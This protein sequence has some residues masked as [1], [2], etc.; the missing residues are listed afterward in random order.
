MSDDKMQLALQVIASWKDTD[1]KKL[2]L[3]KSQEIIRNMIA[4]A[5]EALQEFPWE[6]NK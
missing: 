4:V 1:I 2:D 6:I 5:N 3:K